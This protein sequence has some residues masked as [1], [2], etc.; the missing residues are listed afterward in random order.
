MTAF[1]LATGD[2]DDILRRLLR[3]NGMPSWVDIT[4]EREPSYFTGTH[5]LGPE[6][7]VLGQDGSEVVAMYTAAMRPSH[8][9]GR[10]EL[11]GY[12]GGLRVGLRHRHRIRYLRAGF[13]SVRT[14]APA[15]GTVPWWF[16]V[17][18]EGN[19]TALR[20][21]ERALPGLPTYRRLGDYVTYVL[22]TSRGR[23]LNLWR[24]AWPDEG[25]AIVDFYNRH[26]AGLQCSP[27]L[28]VATVERIG[29]EHFLVHQQGNDMLGAVALWDQRSFKQV[30]AQRY[31]R[32]LGSLLPAYNLY[33]RLCR[34]VP[35]PQTGDALAQTFLAFLAL[36]EQSPSLNEALIS[37]ALSHCRTPAAALGLHARHP[38]LEI[39]DRFKPIRYPVRVYAV[40]FGEAVDLDRRAVQP[41]SALL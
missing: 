36:S 1:R 17:I 14:L 8:V 25:T 35:L 4:I 11:L 6:W 20:L 12:L 21:L 3:D 41:E 27:V 37:D 40:T 30:V 34:R 26:A 29:P 5:W 7:A 38:L 28:D 39:I 32:P 31:R 9:N 22:P 24:P 23:R 10:R 33:A 19:A 18:A 2:D 15:H 13:E 16:T